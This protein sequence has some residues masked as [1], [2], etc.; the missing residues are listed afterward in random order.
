MYII[1]V[2]DLKFLPFKTWREEQK[3]DFALVIVGIFSGVLVAVIV[4][5]IYTHFTHWINGR[6]LSREEW[7]AIPAKIIDEL[8]LKF[9]DLVEWSVIK[10][11]DKMSACMSKLQWTIT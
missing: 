10:K 8:E 3:I 11:G 9:E 5:F 2:R 7:V 4:Y 1:Y 6:Q